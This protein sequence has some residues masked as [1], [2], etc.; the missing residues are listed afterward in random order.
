MSTNLFVRTIKKHLVDQQMPM[1]SNTKFSASTIVTHTLLDDDNIAK[2][3]NLGDAVDVVVC[4]RFWALNCPDPASNGVGV[5]VGSSRKL[6]FFQLDIF[7]H[8]A[9]IKGKRRRGT[10]TWTQLRHENLSTIAMEKTVGSFQQ[11]SIAC[12]AHCIH[13]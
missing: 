4:G 8:L 5:L 10:I 1:N 13:A 9:A 3:L 12:P 2:Y 6:S 7:R 11:H